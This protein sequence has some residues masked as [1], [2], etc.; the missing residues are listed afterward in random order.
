MSSLLPF[1]A[2]TDAAQIDG[3]MS[4]IHWLMLVL[5][6]GWGVYFVWVLVRFRAARQPVAHP[7]GAR[8]RVAFWTEV[9]VIAAEAVLLVVFALPLWFN[10][11]AAQPSGPEAVVVRVVA[12]QFAWNVHYPGADGV[13]GATSLSLVSPTNPLG[14]DRRSPAGRD[15]V[16][17][18][19]Q[20][21]L[22][23]N[24][25]AIVQLTSKDVIHSFGVPAMRVK[26]DAVPGLTSPVWFTP[27]RE[28]TFEVACSQLC[29]LA[30]FRMRATIVV[31]S[32][33]AFRQFLAA[34]ASAQRVP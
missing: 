5:F 26:R 23:I 12:E 25:P 21:R 10:R 15:D 11:T 4:L 24:R 20:I 27:S 34:E 16:V 7:T 28:G 2:S 18:L 32:D 6:V 1:P 22:P 33:A 31:E 14:L 9:G 30:H 19:N 17:E 29:G 3:L 13:F 8:G